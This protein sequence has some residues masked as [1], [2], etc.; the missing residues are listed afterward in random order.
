MEKEDRAKQMEP[1]AGDAFGRYDAREAMAEY[2][3]GKFKQCG[4]EITH[5]PPQAPGSPPAWTPP[6]DSEDRP[7]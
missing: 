5:P 4:W 3:A 1:G 2:V 6:V 7:G